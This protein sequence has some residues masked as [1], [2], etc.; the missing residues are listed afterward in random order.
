MRFWFR[1]AWVLVA[2]WIASSASAVT[3]SWTAIGNP[4][5]A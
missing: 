1:S 5:S 3:M 2:L 4:G